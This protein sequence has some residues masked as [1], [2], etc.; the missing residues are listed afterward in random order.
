MNQKIKAKWVAALRSGKYKQGKNFLKLRDE[1]CCLGV[2]CDISGLAEWE[3]RGKS[4]SSIMPGI[5]ISSDTVLPS[6]VAKWAGIVNIGMKGSD[7][8]V[9]G[10]LMTMNDNGK[11][12]TEIAAVIQEKL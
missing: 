4:Y 12:F 7:K 6:V 1:F 9:I 3:H 11:T 10:K 5:Y 2:L 8:K